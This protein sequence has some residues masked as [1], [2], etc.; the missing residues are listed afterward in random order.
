MQA[1]TPSHIPG[2][3]LT[4]GAGPPGVCRKGQMGSNRVV[5]PPLFLRAVPEMK[6]GPPVLW[7]NSVEM[8]LVWASVQARTVTVYNSVP[9]Y[10]VASLP[11]TKPVTKPKGGRPPFGDKAMSAVERMRR[12]LQHLDM[13]FLI[14]FR[15]DS[16]G[17][18]GPVYSRCRYRTGAGRPPDMGSDTHAAFGA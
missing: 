9:I 10:E 11:V 17:H 4:V 3:S 13:R 1:S 6:W 5:C 7:R 16:Y 15:G 12:R 18:C 8:C 2:A 14:P